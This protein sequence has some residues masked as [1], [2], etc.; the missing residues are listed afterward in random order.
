VLCRSCQRQIVS[1]QEAFAAITGGGRGQPNGPV[2]TY[3]GFLNLV[4]R[5]PPQ[6]GGRLLSVSVVPEEDQE[7]GQFE[8]YFC[9]VQCLRNQLNVHLEC[10]E[11]RSY[12]FLTSNGEVDC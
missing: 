7:D 1:E 12:E 3:V 10:L 6:I 11:N 8:L 4:W 2:S 5:A 9:S